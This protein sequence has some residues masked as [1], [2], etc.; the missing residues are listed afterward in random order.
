ME[1][2]HDTIV[3]E[4]VAATTAEAVFTA[5]V[6][7]ESRPRWAVPEGEG[8]RIDELDLRAGGI[9]RYECGPADSLGFHVTVEHLV[10]EAPHLILDREQVVGPDGHLLGTSLVTW[11]LLPDP[12][13]VRIRETVQVVSTVGAGMTEGTRVGTALVL[14][15][16]VA[17]LER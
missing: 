13:G 6:D 15:R 12:A 5:F 10:V 9:D 8:L 11:E 7:R 2:A 4:R 3:E 16:L 1:I 14:D 17:H